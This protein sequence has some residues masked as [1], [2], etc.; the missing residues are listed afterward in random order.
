MLINV[1]SVLLMKHHMSFGENSSEWQQLYLRCHILIYVININIFIKII[2]YMDLKVS[3][4]ILVSTPSVSMYLSLN[5]ND[6]DT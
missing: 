5:L 2:K 1:V 3:I 6:S 4:C